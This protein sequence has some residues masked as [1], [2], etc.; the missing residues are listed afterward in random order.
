M[1]G[2]NMQIQEMA[3]RTGVAPKTI[4]YYESIDLLPP[5]SRKQ[6]GYRD[7]VEADL[8]RVRFVAGARRL[9]FS[10]AEIA[11]ILDL[12]DGG[13]A[14]CAVLLDQL[15]LKQQ[16]IQTRITQLEQLSDALGELH[17]RGLEFPQD[18]VEGK[19]CVCHLIK[20]QAEGD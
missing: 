15:Q 13:V 8:D 5:P 19:N 17:A 4:R 6:N 9:D 14:P 7:Y 20:S 18:D 2:G 10:L 1:K 12:R 3:V 16:E 11:E